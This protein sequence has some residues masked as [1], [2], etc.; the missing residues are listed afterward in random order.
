GK[1]L[2][3]FRICHSLRCEKFQRDEAIERFLPRLVNHAHAPA[4]KAFED[5]ELRKI[6]GQFLRCLRGH[7]G[8]RA[9]RALRGNSQ[10][11][12]Q[13]PR[14]ESLRSLLWQ[15]CTAVLALGGTGR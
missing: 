5:F 13:A 11:R 6:W 4:T 7:L 14:T 10:P 12:K 2:R 1:V 9:H 15:T 8:R 3:E